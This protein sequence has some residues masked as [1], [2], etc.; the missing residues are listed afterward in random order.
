M[1]SKLKREFEKLLSIKV[2]SLQVLAFALMLMIANA[3][4]F[5][6]IING[7]WLFGI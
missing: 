3:S 2:T 7:G 5:A 4:M 6:L 1:S